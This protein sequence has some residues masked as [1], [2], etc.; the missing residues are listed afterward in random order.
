MALLWVMLFSFSNRPFSFSF[1][2]SNDLSSILICFKLGRKR[3][4]TTKVKLST[5]SLGGK[6]YKSIIKAV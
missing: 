4:Y 3:E 6:Y 1:F 5:Y 2:S